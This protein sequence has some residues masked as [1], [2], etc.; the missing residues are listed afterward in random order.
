MKIT[1]KNVFGG[2]I[3][4]QSSPKKGA[5]SSEM[6]IEIK[7]KDKT[8]SSIITSSQAY[9]NVKGSASIVIFKMR[10]DF[11][12]LY[13]ALKNQ[14]IDPTEDNIVTINICSTELTI[15]K[16]V[17]R[18][19][20]L[21]DYDINDEDT[22][23]IV[24]RFIIKKPVLLDVMVEVAK[25]LRLIDDLGFAIKMQV[26]PSDKQQIKK[27]RN[28]SKKYITKLLIENNKTTTSNVVNMRSPK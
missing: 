7:H 28:E 16:M 5:C 10:H 3:D 26:I 2:F 20:E 21:R 19:N 24:L 14:K 6:D 17:E 8:I 25:V 1:T 23:E 15:T 22:L 13:D 12:K 11:M 9:N 4:H 27:L 18:I